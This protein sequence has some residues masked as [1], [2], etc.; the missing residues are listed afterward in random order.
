MHFYSCPFDSCI[1]SYL[2]KSQSIQ[3]P[4]SGKQRDVKEV[5]MCTQT[6]VVLYKIQNGAQTFTPR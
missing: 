5:E 3:V 1:L 2:E 4:L 6:M